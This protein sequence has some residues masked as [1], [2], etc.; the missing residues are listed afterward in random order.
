MRGW[1]IAAFQAAAFLAAA[2]AESQTL[3]AMPIPRRSWSFESPLGSFDLASAQRGYAVYAQVCA[4]CHSMR[5]VR[6]RDLAGLGLDHDEISAIASARKAAPDG[7]FPPSYPSDAAA[8][9]ANNGVVPPDLSRLARTIP[10]GASFIDAY[11]TGFRPTPPNVA[12]DPGMHYNLY[13]PGRA[14]A[15]PNPLHDGQMTFLGGGAATAASMARDVSTFL[16]WAARPHLVER[17]RLGVRVLTYLFLLLVLVTVIKRRVW[18]N[19]RL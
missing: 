13:I 15:M 7:R 14:V 11:L 10:G 3:S 9:A 18:S 8:R 4:A 5:Q 6:F 16:A 1:R 19:V 17:R 12:S 2:P